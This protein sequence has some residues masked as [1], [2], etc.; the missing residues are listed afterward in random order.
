MKNFEDERIS[1][2]IVMYVIGKIQTEN[3]PNLGPTVGCS[4]R[5]TGDVGVPA[6]RANPGNG[7]I[8]LYPTSVAVTRTE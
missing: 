2:E 4:P 3:E 1:Y 6:D 8:F 7:K 5:D